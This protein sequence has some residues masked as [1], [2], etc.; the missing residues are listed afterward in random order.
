MLW[1]ICFADHQLPEQE[2]WLGHRNITETIIQSGLILN[3]PK[4][5]PF[6]ALL[7][8]NS[9]RWCRRTDQPRQQGVV[10]QLPPIMTW[11]LSEQFSSQLV[12]WN[13]P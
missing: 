13:D 6:S 8:T 3:P 9:L 5:P 4:K 7:E 10:I 12:E 1:D 11:F 2:G